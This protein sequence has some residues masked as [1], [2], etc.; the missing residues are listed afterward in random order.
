MP[1]SPDRRLAAILTRTGRYPERR[2]RLPADSVAWLVIAPALFAA[3][4][5]FVAW[6]R[7]HPDLDTPEFI[8]STFSQA[9]CRFGVGV[10][11]TLPL[12]GARPMTTHQTIGAFPEEWRLN[13]IGGT[14]MDLPDPPE[15]VR[16]CDHPLIR[17][18]HIRCSVASFAR[19]SKGDV[20]QW[21]SNFVENTRTDA[22]ERLKC[23]CDTNDAMQKAARRSDP[24]WATSPPLLPSPR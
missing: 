7:L 17:Q 2:C 22:A 9:R 5:I 14:D 12:E 23:G 24:E 16:T 3:A 1:L 19:T 13:G 6:R 11:R 20:P 21:R 10:R 4:S 8:D 18:P 15:D